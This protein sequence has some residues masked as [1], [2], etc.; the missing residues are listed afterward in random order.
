MS[1][2][3]A[4]LRRSLFSL[5]HA[6]LIATRTL[7]QPLPRPLRCARS[8]A[9]IVIFALL[10]AVMLLGPSAGSGAGSRPVVWVQAGHEG[11]REPGY[12]AQTGSGSGPF[13]SEV[14]FTTRLAAAVESR[15]RAAGVDARH[16]PGLVTPI[17]S[18]GATFVSLHH[19][20]PGGYAR[21][22][23]A[24]TG[25]NENYYRGEGFGTA[26][27]TPYPD[28][29]PH[30]AA[31]RVSPVVEGRSR[32]LAQRLSTR[33]RAVHTSRNGAASRFGGVEPRD[34]NVRMM[35]YYGYYRTRA[36]ARVLI[37]AGAGGADDGY[38]ARVDLIA[39]AVTDG[40]VDDLRVRGLL[41]K[42]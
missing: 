24:I 16:T 33:L 26:R 12:R 3:P 27:P 36:D 2:F 31:T 1:G 4:S 6:L 30:R 17:G 18:P 40:V 14:A 22:G 20:A 9:R 29:A 5:G 41:P 10:V 15:L 38:L 42:S 32:Y 34:G 8:G 19:D 13:R 39:D 21:I 11:P 28:S 37:E 25:A 7:R 35:R 23:H